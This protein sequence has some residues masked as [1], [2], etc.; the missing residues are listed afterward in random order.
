MTEMIDLLTYIKKESAQNAAAMRGDITKR[1]DQ[2]RSY[3]QIGHL[4]ES[5]VSAPPGAKGYITTVEGVA[6]YYLFP[7]PYKSKEVSLV[8]TIRRG[9]RMPL[10]DSAYVAR[11]TDELAKLAPPKDPPAV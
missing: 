4:D 10:D 9:S 11:W 2:M 5:A 8:L 1:L 6:I 7:V 3:P